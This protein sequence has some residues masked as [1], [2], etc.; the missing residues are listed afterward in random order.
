MSDD[1]VILALDVPDMEAAIA[2]VDRLPDVSFWKV[3][4]ELFISAGPA[5]LQAL[6]Q[7]H[8][9]IFLDL[10][11]HDIPNTMAGAARVVGRYG[12]DL[13]TV[14]GAAGLPALQAVQQAA[15]AGATEAGLA[16]PQV[17]AVTLLTSI[18]ADQLAQEL[19]VPIAV[20][21]YTRHVTQLSQTAGLAGVVCS[22]QEAA[23]LRSTYGDD[24]VLVCP[25]VRPT[26]AASGDQQRTLTPREAIAAGATHLVVG[27]P[28]LAAADPVAAWARLQGELA[29]S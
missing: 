16:P 6:K 18:N 9:K 3:G 15:I 1:R 25:G 5:I 26:W 8:K 12:V 22:P 28:V 14:H 11:L 13:L 24:F 20:A 23:A 17:I 7:R 29:E 2:L 19:Q 10:K 27:R 4:L 21:D